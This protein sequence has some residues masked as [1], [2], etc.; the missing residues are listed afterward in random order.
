[1]ST[2]SAK[3]TGLD[4]MREKVDRLP[5]DVTEKLR[6]V[7]ERT[8][9]TIKQRARATLLTKRHAP[10]TADSI[11]VMAHV[12]EKRYEVLVAGD[13]ARPANLPLWLERGT[14]FM[15]ATPYLRPA[16]DAENQNYIRDSAAA[17]VAAVTESLK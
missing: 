9:G 11:E 4:E 3:S 1:M 2:G 17:A 10:K 8:A 13:P 5:A 14:V 15:M 16:Q 12:G 7:A 6:A